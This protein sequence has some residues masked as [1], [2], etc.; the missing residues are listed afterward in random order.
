MTT[1]EDSPTAKNQL[2]KI[3]LLT[4][5]KFSSFYAEL[6]CWIPNPE[7]MSSKSLSSSKFDSAFHPSNVGQMSKTE[8]EDLILPHSDSVP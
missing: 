4:L 1:T 8:I 7:V 2:A 6:R 5:A 3:N